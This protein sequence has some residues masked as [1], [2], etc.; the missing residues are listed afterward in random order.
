M[1][2]DA[3]RTGIEHV[4]V[5]IEIGSRQLIR[6]NSHEFKQHVD[7]SLAL[8][9]RHIALDARDVV[10]IDATGLGALLYAKRRAIEVKGTFVILEPN[11]DLTTLFELT[12]LNTALVIMPFVDWTNWTNDGH[13]T[14]RD[15]LVQDGGR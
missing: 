11:D 7:A 14:R 8:G 12:K 6:E 4:P 5:L 9:H 1:S 15:V 10:Y 13:R 3:I 2:T